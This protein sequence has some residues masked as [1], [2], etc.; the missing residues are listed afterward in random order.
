MT[1]DILEYSAVRNIVKLVEEHRPN[2]NGQCGIDFFTILLWLK[3]KGVKLTEEQ[4]EV[5]I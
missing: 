4:E 1:E 3:K 5:L 2:C